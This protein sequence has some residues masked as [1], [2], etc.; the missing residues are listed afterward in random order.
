MTTTTE[1]QKAETGPFEFKVGEA[2]TTLM[3]DG[4]TFDVTPD[5]N[6]TVHARSVQAK[7]TATDESQAASGEPDPSVIISKDRK[8]ASTY[9]TE[10]TLPE[11][12][13]PALV[14]AKAPSVW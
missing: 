1:N 11:E 8:T 3:K 12:G 2:Q 9:G 4:A 13:G 10:I 5:S 6:V 14:A 7:Q